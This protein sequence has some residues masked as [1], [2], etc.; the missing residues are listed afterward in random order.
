LKIHEVDARAIFAKYGVPVPPSRLV[1]SADEARA[2]ATEIGCPV[3]VKAQVLVGGRGKAGGVKLAATPDEAAAKA[4]AILGMDIKG[5]TVEKVLVARAV[6][7]AK[8]FYVGMVIDRR[9]RKPLMMVSPAGGIDIEEVARTTPEKIIKVVVDPIFGI[10]P[11]QMRRMT[12]ALSGEKEIAKQVGVILA[13]LYKAFMAL[14]ASLAEINPLVVTPAGEVWAIDA[15]INIDDSGLYRH[16]DIAALRDESSEDIGE[17]EAREAGLSF[18]KLDGTI[19]CIVNGAGLAM[20]TMDMIKHFGGEPANFL[21]IGGSS[22]PEKVLSA[23]KIILRD[24]NVKT[25]L[26]NIFG[27][28]TR[29]DDV[30]T[31]LI[32]AKKQLG[33]D[34]PLVVRLTGTNEEQA[35]EILKGTALI[36]AATMEEGVKRAIEAAKR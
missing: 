1:L 8:E 16:A 5:I 25:I 32:E 33:L 17:V 15:K 14:D 9:S 36:S 18:V 7:I 29:C 35:R 3:V 28:I 22:S 24:G 12:S 20:A 31:G 21:D 26:I 2:A 11:F 30:A 34:I 13:S 19:G 4:K 6:D 23:M 10:L 27:G